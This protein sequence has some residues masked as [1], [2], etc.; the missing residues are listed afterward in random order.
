MSYLQELGFPRWLSR[1]VGW[2]AFAYVGRAVLREPLQPCAWWATLQLKALGL[3]SRLQPTPA[4]TASWLGKSHFGTRL[5]PIFAAGQAF[6][7]SVLEWQ[8]P[9]TLEFLSLS[10]FSQELPHFPKLRHLEGLSTWV[11]AYRHMTYEVPWIRYHTYQAWNS[12]ASVT[13]LEIFLRIGPWH[14]G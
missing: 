5:Q 11:G 9:A 10:A 1:A 14:H 12:W 8:V 7:I 13:W 4:F 2:F 6:R 3:G